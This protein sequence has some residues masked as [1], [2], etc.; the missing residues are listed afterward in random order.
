MENRQYNI[1]FH[2]HTVS[3]IVIS[4]LLYVIFFAGSFSF[5]RDE[6]VNW[7]RNEPVP[8]K[9][10]LSINIDTALDTLQ[11][12]YELYGREISFT[13]GYD[14]RRVMVNVSNSSDTLVTGDGSFFYMDT[15]TYR[16]HEYES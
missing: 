1:F 6:I 10:K 14:E 12:K 16:T 13:R 3:G 15:R 8:E 7:E 4:V 2:L 11:K 5:F 9:K